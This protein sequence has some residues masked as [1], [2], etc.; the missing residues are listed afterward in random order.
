MWLLAFS[1]VIFH[2][3][4]SNMFMDQYLS[5]HIRAHPHMVHVRLALKGTHDAF[6]LKESC[7]SVSVRL[8]QV[9]TG[10]T[11]R[12]FCEWQRFNLMYSNHQTW[13]FDIF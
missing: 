6:L 5:Y 3:N 12:R 9:E 7:V 1:F 8:G 10:L 13:D 4:N 11:T 2:K